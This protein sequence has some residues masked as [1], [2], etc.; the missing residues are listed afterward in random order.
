MK[1]TRITISIIALILSYITLWWAMYRNMDVVA[2]ST[3]LAMLLTPLYTY[4]FAKTKEN[5][6]KE[7]EKGDGHVI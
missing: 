1:N 5:M 7:Q 6:N 2:V 4:L 3:A